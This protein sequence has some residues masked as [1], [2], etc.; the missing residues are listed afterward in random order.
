MVKRGVYFGRG[1]NRFRE[2][3]TVAYRYLKEGIFWEA[4]VDSGRVSCRCLK[5]GYIL[6]RRWIPGVSHIDV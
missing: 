3:P 2:S 1:G 6:G 4:E 5:G